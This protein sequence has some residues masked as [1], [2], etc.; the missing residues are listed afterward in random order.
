MKRFTTLLMGLL[1][2]AVGCIG[3]LGCSDNSAPGLATQAS[4]NSTPVLTQVTI[5]APTAA[6][7]TSTPAGVAAL[8]VAAVKPVA[9]VPAV[10]KL[11]NV[12]GVS[13]ISLGAPAGYT[14]SFTNPSS[15][16][17]VLTFSNPTGT[18]QTVSSTANKLDLQVNPTTGNLE[19]KPTLADAG[20]YAELPAGPVT[21]ALPAITLTPSV[22]SRTRATTPH[23]LTLSGITFT[24]SITDNGW[25]LPN[26][27]VLQLV[28]LADGNYQLKGAVAYATWDGTAPAS[29]TLANLQLSGVV[30]AVTLTTRNYLR[31]TGADS[32]KISIT[33]GNTTEFT[34]L[35][36]ASF[37][38]NN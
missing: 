21:F 1:L 36:N 16:A 8:A 33:S 38:F 2:L 35:S 19:I 5:L 24:C 25:N 9:G 20:N 22:K 23:D 13:T 7:T 6:D 27:Q 37:T 29:V 30:P 26:N 11:E 4:Q 3:F 28:Q 32:N 15:S 31:G 17:Q 12:G 14:L 10:A 18:T 34:A